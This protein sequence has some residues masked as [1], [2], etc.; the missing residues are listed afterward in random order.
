MT[1]DARAQGWAEVLSDQSNSGLTKKAFC[2]ERQINI[3]T[4]YYWQKRFRE[5]AQPSSTGFDRLEPVAIHELTVCLAH[6]HVTLRS[7][8]ADT[9]GQ[10]ILALSHA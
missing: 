7:A 2:A 1:K 4:F 3:A 5:T 6:R 9:L 10:V 8:S